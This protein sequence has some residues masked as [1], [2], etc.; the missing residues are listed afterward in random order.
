MLAFPSAPVHNLPG[1]AREGTVVGRASRG[2]RLRPAARAR[3][4]AARAV[5][6]GAARGLSWTF[7]GSTWTQASP[8]Q[9]PPARSGASLT[10]DTAAG[11]EVLFGG[12]DAAG[13]ALGDAWAYDGST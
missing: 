8:A 1:L 11:T 7:D 4:R 13:A 5:A 2:D 9:S 6:A 3:V 12:S 10:Y